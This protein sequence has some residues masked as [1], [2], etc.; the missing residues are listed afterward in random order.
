MTTVTSSPNGTGKLW[1]CTNER[2]RREFFHT[3]ASIPPIQPHPE[4]TEN[5]QGSIKNLRNK[6]TL[7]SNEMKQKNKKQKKLDKEEVVDEIN[8]I[9]ASSNTIINSS[10]SVIS[11]QKK[12]QIDFQDSQIDDQMN[13]VIINKQKF[14]S[15]NRSH[16][17]NFEKLK[18]DNEGEDEKEELDNEE[19]QE[20]AEEKEYVNKPQPKFRN[21]LSQTKTSVK[22]QS[23]SHYDFNSNEE[24]QDEEAEE[25]QEE[26]EEEESPKITRTLRTKRVIIQPSKPSR[27]SLR[28]SKETLNSNESLVQDFKGRDVVFVDPLDKNAGFWWPAMIV[29][30]DELDES[31]DFDCDID[32]LLLEG[33][34]LVKYFEDMTYS[35]VEHKGLKHFMLG[36][37]PYLTFVKKK[38]FLDHIGVKRA[39][40]CIKNNGEPS[41]SFQWDYWKNPLGKTKDN[42]RS[43]TNRRIIATTTNN[44]AISRSFAASKPNN[45][46]Y[47]N[48][49]SIQTKRFSDITPPSSIRQIK[50]KS[51]CNNN[52]HNRH[53]SK[54]A[55]T[56]QLNKS[57]NRKSMKR[58]HSS[59]S[60]KSEFEN[61]TKIT[62]HHNSAYYIA[63]KSR[64][65]RHTSEIDLMDEDSKTETYSDVTIEELFEEEHNNYSTDAF[66]IE[67]PLIPQIS[68]E[69]LSEEARTN[70]SRFNFKDPDL[71]K[72]AKEKLYEE[73]E[74]KLRSLCKEYRTA[75]KDLKKMEKDLFRDSVDDDEESYANEGVEVF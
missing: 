2:L 49:D 54:S 19:E 63:P 72:K 50:N 48:K 7:K 11:T 33:N 57:Y 70:L 59:I 35:V 14:E 73:A 32:H 42:K 55:N 27:K 43:V 45:K 5:S 38:G 20:G 28:H 47:K 36:D 69:N 74:E 44:R 66:K 6:K 60:L 41:K 22:S 16:L 68:I 31:M 56:H 40:K 15:R 34:F 58:N 71:D 46:K 3:G 21:K 25:I 9:T 29:P 65:L 4:E 75:M 23:K 61:V 52:D 10:V 12:L 62:T 8:I 51:N 1:Y 39:L 13:G 18:A 17:K 37:E 53:S 24:E 26:L 30:N 64:K 67:I